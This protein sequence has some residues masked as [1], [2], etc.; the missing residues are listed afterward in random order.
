M[1][2]AEGLPQPSRAEIL[3]KAKGMDGILW[4]TH[5]ALNGEALDAAGP[6]LKSLSTMSAGLDY[7]DLP[8]VRKRGIPIGY[9]PTVLDDAV[10]DVAVG[11]MIA[12]ARRFHEGLLK[13]EHS[14]WERRPQWMLGR[15]IKGSTVGIVGLGGI[16]QTIVKRLGGFDVGQFLYT[17][18]SEKP[19]AE[20]LKAKF[21]TFDELLAESDFVFIACPLTNETRKLFNADVFNKMKTTSMLINVARGDIVDQDALY[22]ALKEN[23][24]F[25]AGLDV[26][27]PEPLPS[28]HKLLKLPNIVI[29]PHLGSATIRTRNDMSV[30]AAHNVLRGIA[31]EPMFAPVP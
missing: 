28:D 22:D 24:I 7:V 25:S 30:I 31:G 4:L 20:D 6:Q 9:T 11:L 17:G 15:D 23:K 3:E 16:G 21:V 14:E 27:T 29:I 18:H 8:E 5:E 19:E 12:A 26:T 1:T 2:F 10:A 13:I